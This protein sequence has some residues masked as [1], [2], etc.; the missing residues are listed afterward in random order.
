MEEEEQEDA[1]RIQEDT[2]A[3]RP[4]EL[5]RVRCRTRAPSAHSAMSMDRTDFAH[6]RATRTR[7]RRE[8]EVQTGGCVE[9]C[10]RK[11]TASTEDEC[12]GGWQHG[13][14]IWH[15]GAGIHAQWSRRVLR[16]AGDGR[17]HAARWGGAAARRKGR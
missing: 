8:G 13:P 2:R 16:G 1:K 7:T 3:R 10:P 9:N 12:A 6:A 11:S 14:V 17:L 4:R 15:D 5:K